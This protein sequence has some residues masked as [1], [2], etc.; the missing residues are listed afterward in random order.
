MTEG[1]SREGGR[2]KG[3]NSSNGDGRGGYWFVKEVTVRGKKKIG[4]NSVTPLVTD[5]NIA[6][7]IENMVWVLPPQ[8]AF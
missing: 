5:L 7:N 8:D 1:K 6:T 3:V 2:G 4:Y